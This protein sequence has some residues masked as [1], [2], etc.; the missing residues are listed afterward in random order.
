MLDFAT[1][2]H[3]FRHAGAKRSHGI[4]PACVSMSGGYGR[5]TRTRILRPTPI[6]FGRNGL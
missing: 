1:K 3:I 6:R 4:Y 2:R 5:R